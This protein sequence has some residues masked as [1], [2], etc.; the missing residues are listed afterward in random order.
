MHIEQHH[1]GI[2]THAQERYRTNYKDDA[3]PM[4]RLYKINKRVNSDTDILSTDIEI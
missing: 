2:I 4:I 1:G 3:Q